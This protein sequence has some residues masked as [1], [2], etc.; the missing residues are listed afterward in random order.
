[1]N[2]TVIDENDM[3]SVGG[4]D[5]T[6]PGDQTLPPEEV[7]NCFLP[8]DLTYTRLS[9]IRKIF[10]SRFKGEVYTIKTT[11]LES[12]FTA[13]PNHPILTR[14]GWIKTN[15]LQN[16]DELVKYSSIQSFVSTKVNDMPV[17]FEQIYNSMVKVSD[18]CV[19]IL[20][21]SVDFHG[22]I[23]DSEVNVIIQKGKLWDRIKSVIAQMSKNV[24]FKLSNYIHSRFSNFSQFYSC[25]IDYV[26]S[27]FFTP[28]LITD[29][30][31]FS[32]ASGDDSIFA[33]QSG[34]CISPSGI[35]ADTV[36]DLLITH[37]AFIQ[38]HKVIDIKCHYYDGLVYTLETDSQMYDVNGYTAKNCRCT[39]AFTPKRN[40]AGRLIPK[41]VT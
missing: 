17:T 36:C 19:R 34:N 2:G 15:E 4:N 9:H 14:R 41:Q 32:I 25:F 33:Q 38:F 23:P 29:S 31:K 12:G 22:D 16:G 18:L 21:T 35:K 3:F 39:M 10:R 26:K 28:I 8:T 1:V 13:T 11:N 30:I 37:A 6:G 20:A 27:F 24:N 7:C 5:A 40:A